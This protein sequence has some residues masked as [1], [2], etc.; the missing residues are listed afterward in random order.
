M[1]THVGG[2]MNGLTGERKKVQLLQKLKCMQPKF[3]SALQKNPLK[4]KQKL[5]EQ[6]HGTRQNKLLNSM[7]QKSS[8]WRRS[9]RN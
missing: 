1:F 4:D 3:S 8:A 7:R 5:F 6:Q 9:S 2:E